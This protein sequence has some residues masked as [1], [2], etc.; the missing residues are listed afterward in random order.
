MQIGLENTII[1]LNV[2]A[3]HQFRCAGLGWYRTLEF[4]A[5]LGGFPLNPPGS[6]SESA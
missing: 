5:R 1:L 2:Q 3:W 6:H 4:R